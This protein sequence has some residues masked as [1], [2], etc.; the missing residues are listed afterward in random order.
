[1]LHF[2]N[3]DL[4]GLLI[5]P[6]V[7]PV[8]VEVRQFPGQSVVLTDP[9]GVESGQAWLLVRTGVTCVIKYGYFPPLNC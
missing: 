9:D 2:S 7:I 4:P 3:I 1:M 5:E 6:L 8:G